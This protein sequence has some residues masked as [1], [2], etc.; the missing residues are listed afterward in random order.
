MS[1]T[2]DLPHA[3]Q[4]LKKVVF[5]DMLLD[6]VRREA[7]AEFRKEQYERIQRHIKKRTNRGY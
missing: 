7:E 6:E 2:I 3:K 1:V 5:K 4:D